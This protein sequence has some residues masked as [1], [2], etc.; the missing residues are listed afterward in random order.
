MN[1]IANDLPNIATVYS[2]DEQPSREP[3]KRMIRLF[4]DEDVSD[5]PHVPCEYLRNYK[6]KKK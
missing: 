4:N 5:E 1:E 2:F 3:V 6:Y